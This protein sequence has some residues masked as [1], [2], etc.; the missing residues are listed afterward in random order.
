MTPLP[1]AFLATPLAHRGL[2]D[3]RKGVIE[4][5]RSAVAAAVDAG[6][7]VEIDLQLSA[8]GEAMV[9]HDYHL[10]RLTAASGP[11]A[12]VSAADLG[13]LTLTDGGVYD[14]LGVNPLMRLQ[15]NDLQYALVSDGGKPFAISADPTESGT[16]VLKEAIGIL[17]EQVRGLQFQRMA[18]AH[19]AGEGPRPM[20]FSIDSSEGE[21]HPGDAQFAS[22]ISTNLTRL[23]AVEMDVLTRHS[24][25]LCQA[26]IEKYAP[27]LIG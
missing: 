26:R 22:M 3:R 9:F 11:V 8:D 20:W 4:N 25:A 27:E 15:R 19:K 13:R 14:N 16:I 7:G 17:M 5:S 6:Y 12:Q 2:H 23:S 18:L 21:I 1:T 24:G 10:D